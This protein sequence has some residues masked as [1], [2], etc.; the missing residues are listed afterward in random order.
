MPKHS[1]SELR[2]R[3]ADY[4]HAAVSY[5]DSLALA[6]LLWADG[7]FL[8]RVGRH[9]V[10]SDLIEWTREPYPAAREAISKGLVTHFTAYPRIGTVSVAYAG[11][12]LGDTLR[13]LERM[14]ECL[15]SAVVTDGRLGWMFW[16]LEERMH[17][18]EAEDLRALLLNRYGRS[19]ATWVKDAPIPFPRIVWG[20]EL[21]GLDPTPISA[22]SLWE[23]IG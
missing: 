8:V 17:P 10:D 4:D 2:S 13:A 21:H 15:P 1:F 6:D 14:D 19:G 5:A 22:A 9:R 18:S 16:K 12:S 11:L 23:M 20:V 3:L 7:D